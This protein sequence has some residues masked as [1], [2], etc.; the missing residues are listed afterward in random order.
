MG[1]STSAAVVIFAAS[2]LY[3]ATI[4]YPLVER[5]YRMALEAEKDSNELRYEKLNT[6]IV[7]TDT[8]N[9]GSDLSVTVYNNGSVTL[10]SSRLNVIHNGTFITS[11][12]VS[13]QGVWSPRNFINVTINGVTG[14]RVKIVT[15]NGAADYAVT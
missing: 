4:Y 3:M 7:I 11:F 6:K 12:T 10:N 15:E 2:L 9:T 5:S 8:E 14:G 1:F 13:R